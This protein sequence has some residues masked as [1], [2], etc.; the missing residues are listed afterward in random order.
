MAGSG[1]PVPM[2]SPKPVSPTP[3]GRKEEAGFAVYLDPRLCSIV[4]N[5]STSWYTASSGLPSDVYPASGRRS[6]IGQRINPE[7]RRARSGPQCWGGL[8]EGL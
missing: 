2:N 5:R 7:E 4:D 1:Q 3:N 6:T 8:E